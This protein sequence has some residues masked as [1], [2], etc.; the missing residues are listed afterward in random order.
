MTQQVLVIHG[1]S[2]FEKYDEYIKHLKNKEITL[3]RLRF[4]GWKEN[5]QNSLGSDYEVFNPLMPNRSNARYEEWKII[6]DKII[7]LMDDDVILVGHSLGGIFLAKYL[8]ENIAPKKIKAIFLV[9]APCSRDKRYDLVD[10]V[11]SNDLKKISQQS[12]NI[13]LYHSKDDDKVPFSNLESYIALLPDAHVGVFENNGHFHQ[14]DFPELV[15]DIKS[16]IHNS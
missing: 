7:A 1:G 3:E 9:A 14:T 5:L 4:K 11:I 2:S 8:S 12:K 15:N 6:F 10:F 16:L 13:F